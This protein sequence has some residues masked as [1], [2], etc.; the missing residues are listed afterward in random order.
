[1]PESL[2]RRARP[3]DIRASRRDGRPSPRNSGRL[4]IG[5]PAGIRTLGWHA[6]PIQDNLWWAQA[7]GIG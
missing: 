6:V 1:M 5:I 3:F 4:Q 2:A 7:S